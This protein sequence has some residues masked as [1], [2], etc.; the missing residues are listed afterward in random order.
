GRVLDW[1]GETE[2]GDSGPERV[3]RSYSKIERAAYLARQIAMSARY[4]ED[5][6]RVRAS[7]ELFSESHKEDW[8]ARRWQ[9]EAA[10]AI[11]RAGKIPA[12]DSVL[13]DALQRDYVSSNLPNLVARM[14]RTQ[15][16]RY[17]RAMLAD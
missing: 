12:P 3:L 11:L 8:I 15:F 9:V 6:G 13:N 4:I 16:E 2:I 7:Q 14:N 5:R 17:K 1:T 10:S